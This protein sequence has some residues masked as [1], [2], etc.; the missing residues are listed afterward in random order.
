MKIFSLMALTVAPSAQAQTTQGKQ[1]PA[2][3]KA[4]APAAQK[5]TMSVSD[6][7]AATERGLEQYRRMLKAD[8]W[9]NPA[10]LDSDRGEVLW[11]AKKGPQNVSLAETCDLGKG[12]GKVDGAFA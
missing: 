5:P 9:D 10:L 11:S 1:A 2:A 7:D 6:Q 3:Q 8:P 4:A 12:V